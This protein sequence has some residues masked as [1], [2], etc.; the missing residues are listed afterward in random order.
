MNVSAGVC[1]YMYVHSHVSQRLTFAVF[2]SYSA[3][4]Y[5]YYVISI[6]IAIVIIRQPL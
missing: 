4:Y 3:Y 6:I 5:Y 2:L 1:M